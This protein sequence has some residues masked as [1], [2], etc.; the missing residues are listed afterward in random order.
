MPGK[1]IRRTAGALLFDLPRFA[2]MLVNSNGW[3][4]ASNRGELLLRGAR[5]ILLSGGFSSDV[6]ACAALPFLGRWLMARALAQWSVKFARSPVSVGLPKV[7]FVIPHRGKDRE[8]LL[9]ATIASIMAQEQAS[10]ECVVVE[11]SPVRE[12]IDV[13]AG[14][15][16]IHLQHATDPQP[17]RKSWS[18][19]RGVDL[20]QADLV[21]CHDSDM[22]V[23]ARYASEIVDLFQRENLEVAHLQRFLFCLDQAATHRLL[24]GGAVP[25]V[26][27]ERVRAHWQ[28]G[29]LAIT[30]QAYKKIGGFDESFTGWTG[31]DREF[32]NRCRVLRQSVDGYLPFIH[33]WHPPQASKSGADRERAL[34]HFNRIMMNPRELRIER[35]RKHA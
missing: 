25:D 12:F 21:V 35:L 33:A 34:D 31:E 13:P 2:P 24:R 15:R 18:F 20:A 27:P 29:T 1:S 19:N 32:F 23:P 30:K 4:L 10:V 14:V 28:G 11:Q 16:Y 8:P 7:S 22:L 9:R 3:L 17:W 26:A 5:G 6:H